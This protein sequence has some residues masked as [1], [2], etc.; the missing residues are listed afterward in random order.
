MVFRATGAMFFALVLW[1]GPAHAGPMDDALAAFEA[2]DFEAAVALWTPLAN[3]GNGTA[4]YLLAYMHLT[5]R[6]VPHDYLRAETY[7][8][9]ASEQRDTSGQTLLGALFEQGRG[10]PQNFSEAVW[11]YGLSAKSGDVVAQARLA[12]LYAAGQGVDADPVTAFAWYAAAASQ[13]DQAAAA[14]RDALAQQLSSDD[15]ARARKL[16]ADFQARYRAN[17]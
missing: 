2:Q 16:A 6:G 8:R 12:A 9:L 13:G 3:G 14:S 15:L 4:Q 7:F 1:A 5:G 11:L 10:L 17:P